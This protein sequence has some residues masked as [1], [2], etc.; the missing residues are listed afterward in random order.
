MKRILPILLA[1]LLVS[2]LLAGCVKKSSAAG[3][4]ILKTMNGE[5]LEEQFAPLLDEGMTM[6]NILSLFG[7]TSLDE[8][9]TLELKEDGTLLSLVAGEDP[10]SGTWK[11]DPVSGTW[12]QEGGRILAEIDGETVE[13]TLNG[14]ELSFT[15]EDQAYVFVKK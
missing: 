1:L 7:I 3:T 10:V 12:K 4:Y 11:E 8:Y 13:M 9:F 14:D 2:S 15:E 6:E 5:T